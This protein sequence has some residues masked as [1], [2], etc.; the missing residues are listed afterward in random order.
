MGRR[1]EPISLFREKAS[2]AGHT[3]QQ[4]VESGKS[5]AASVMH[6][7][8]EQL[9]E[10]TEGQS[11]MPKRVRMTAANT[12]ERTSGYLQEHSTGEMLDEA[13]QYVRVHPVQTVIGAAAVGFILARLIR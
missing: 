3:A 7:T 8:A 10:R 1:K 13:E 9:R 12:L 6:R 11:G 2:Q 4:Q 5:Q